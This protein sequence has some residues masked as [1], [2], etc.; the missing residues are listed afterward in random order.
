MIAKG[1]EKARGVGDRRRR[2]AR[3]NNE[4]GDTI[5]EKGSIAFLVIHTY[6]S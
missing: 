1:E 6:S 4:A 5:E 3:E 2:V